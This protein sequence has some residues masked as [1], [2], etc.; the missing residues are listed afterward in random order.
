M[1][2]SRSENIR[3]QSSEW[4]AVHGA[5]GRERGSRAWGASWLGGALGLLELAEV[6]LLDPPC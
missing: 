6:Q 3:V 1:G 2:S 4:R 5:G